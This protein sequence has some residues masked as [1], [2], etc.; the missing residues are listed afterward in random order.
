VTDVTVPAQMNDDYYQ[1][2]QALSAG[3]LTPEEF[4]DRMAEAADRERPNFPE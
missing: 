4:G 1:H 3:E 2:V